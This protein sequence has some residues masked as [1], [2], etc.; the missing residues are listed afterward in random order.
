[1]FRLLIYANSYDALKRFPTVWS[2]R[3]GGK[4]VFYAEHP[5]L[6]ASEQEA[7]ELKQELRKQGFRNVK[8]LVCV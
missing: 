1:M 5:K 7:F 4:K 3:K 2:E 8:V 6:P